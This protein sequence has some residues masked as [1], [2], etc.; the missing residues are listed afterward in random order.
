M[1]EQFSGS[2]SFLHP[3]RRS[4]LFGAL[5]GP[6]GQAALPLHHQARWQQS[7]GTEGLVRQWLSFYLSQFSGW[8]PHFQLNFSFHQSYLYEDLKK[9]L[10][11]L[12]GSVQ[13]SIVQHFLVL[14][15]STTNSSSPGQLLILLPSNFV[16]PPKF[17]RL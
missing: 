3:T 8:A 1:A 13:S 6:G 2:T 10:I 17:L 15:V 7:G 11:A 14:P 4:P 16:F 5:A 9:N 12:E